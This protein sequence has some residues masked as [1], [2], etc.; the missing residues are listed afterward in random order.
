MKNFSYGAGAGAGRLDEYQRAY[1][2]KSIEYMNF[3]I[4]LYIVGFVFFFIA[5]ILVLK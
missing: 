1:C 5:T 4:A 3:K 2:L